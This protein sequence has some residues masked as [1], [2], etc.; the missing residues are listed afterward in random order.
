MRLERLGPAFF[1]VGGVSKNAGKGCVFYI[2]KF[3]VMSEN[4]NCENVSTIGQIA[5]RR[6]R[7]HRTTRCLKARRGQCPDALLF[8]ICP[9]VETF[10]Q[11]KFSDIGK[12]WRKEEAHMVVF[13]NFHSLL[14]ITIPHATH[15]YFSKLLILLLKPILLI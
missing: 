1:R 9:I 15:W 8:A 6:V 3:Q 4:W 10:S 5:N 7:S 11:L 14:I 13:T 12:L 2:S